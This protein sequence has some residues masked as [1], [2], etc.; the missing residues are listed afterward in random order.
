MAEGKKEIKVT[1]QQLL[2]AYR[3]DQAKLEALQRRG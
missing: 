2:E 1:G 3:I